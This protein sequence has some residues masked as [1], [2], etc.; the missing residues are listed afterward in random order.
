MIGKTLESFHAIEKNI[1]QVEKANKQL[2]NRLI[3]MEKIVG[4]EAMLYD[5]FHAV[6]NKLDALNAMIDLLQ[7]EA[8]K[9]QL[10]LDT[11]ASKSIVNEISRMVV[12][13]LKR[14][15]PADE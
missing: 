3:V 5:L 7:L 2:S 10:S 1:E 14:T 4:T 6:K 15:A 12:A 13:A 9:K 8:R 11:I